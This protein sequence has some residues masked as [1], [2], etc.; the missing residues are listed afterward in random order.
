MKCS[1]GIHGR[2]VEGEVVVKGSCIIM[3][4]HPLTPLR[5]EALPSGSSEEQCISL[6]GRGGFE[7]IFQDKCKYVK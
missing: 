7:V 6:P 1:G 4:S 2:E 5:W 3:T